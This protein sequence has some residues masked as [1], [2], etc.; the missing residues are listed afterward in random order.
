ML[1]LLVFIGSGLLLLTMVDRTRVEDSIGTALDD[2]TP[3][4][5]ENAWLTLSSIV[6]AAT[7]RN[8][9]GDENM[10]MDIV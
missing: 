9:R 8:R 10:M 6:A 5:G 3:M 1:L 4:R 7:N 2:G